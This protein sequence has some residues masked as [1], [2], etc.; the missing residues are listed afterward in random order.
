MSK[1]TMSNDTTRVSSWLSQASRE[2]S[3]SLAHKAVYNG[4]KIIFSKHFTAQL[5]NINNQTSPSPPPPAAPASGQAAEEGN[6]GQAKAGLEQCASA[7]LARNGVV[8]EL[9]Q[10]RVER[11]VRDAVVVSQRICH[12]VLRVR[13]NAHSVVC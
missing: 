11:G 8:H 9:G 6:G 1:D 12:V 3:R 4:R 7:G 5:E 2:F 13:G 10:V